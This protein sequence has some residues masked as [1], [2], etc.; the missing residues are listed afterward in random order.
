[1]CF[2]SVPPKKNSRY[3]IARTSS[4]GRLCN[5]SFLE[6]SIIK[7]KSEG[8]NRLYTEFWKRRIVRLGMRPYDIRHLIV[9][10][11][12]ADISIPEKLLDDSCYENA[13]LFLNFFTLFKNTMVNNVLF[14]TRG[15]SYEGRRRSC[16]KRSSQ[17]IINS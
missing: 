7:K 5:L 1:M 11:L 16:R 17:K 3:V 10:R 12:L 13:E 9:V 6:M 14:R 15:C 2:W 8:T 4:T